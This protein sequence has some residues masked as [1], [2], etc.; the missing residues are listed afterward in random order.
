MADT[1]QRKRGSTAQHRVYIGANGEFTYNTDTKTI[2]VHDGQRMGGFPLA[3]ADALT[4]FR[5]NEVSDFTDRDFVVSGVIPNDDTVPQISEGTEVLSV[6]ID[7][8]R[9][10][11]KLD[12]SV[13]GCASPI[14]GGIITLALFVDG[15][16][17]ASQVWAVNATGV[18]YRNIS[19]GLLTEA[20]GKVG[21]VTVSLRVGI[22]DNSNGNG[23]TLGGRNGNVQWGGASRVTLSAKE[24]RNEEL[25]WCG[26]QLS[27]NIPTGAPGRTH[28]LAIEPNGAEPVAGNLLTHRYHHH[29]RVIE[30]LGRVWV[31]YTTAGKNEDQRGLTVV[32]QSSP[33]GTVAFGA[34]AQ[35]F[36]YVFPFN[37]D[38]NGQVGHCIMT[39]N[40]QVLDG[41]LYLVGGVDNIGPNNFFE[42]LA[43]VA[44]EC[45]ADGGLGTPFRISP[46]QYVSPTG[47]VPTYDGILSPQLYAYSKVW[48]M[49]CGSSPS[50]VVQSE[51]V[52]WLNQSGKWFTEPSVFRIDDNPLNLVKT[53]RHISG[54]TATALN[55]RLWI[56]RSRDGG[57]TWGGARR[58][59][60]P[61]VA[62]ASGT[63][64]SD[65][66]VALV[67]NLVGPNRDPL[68]LALF[69]EGEVS[70][71]YYA[72]AGLS[73]T[74]VYPGIYKGGAEAYPDIFEG[75]DSIWISYSA[76][77]EKIYVT[78]VP[79]ALL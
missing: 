8:A 13:S 68:F 56:Q 78:R 62:V 17:S 60:I 39:R 61:N 20:L 32:A 35:A 4:S 18:D 59:D 70:A 31:A 72:R 40:F 19:G 11:S 21:P 26:N 57:L 79:K 65:G 46:D 15:A 47:W 73:P 49:W 50:G 37:A 64:L 76:A 74:P 58:T 43:L 69:S 1:I 10:S 41:K 77:K 71:L 66:R 67:G 30:H 54:N 53:W 51:W 75:S 12:I 5:L 9:K 2:H 45:R 25:S 63:R 16:S 22:N 42:G 14:N 28:Y 29:T 6:V 7:V 44:V 33:I 48:G 38:D 3:R 52:G 36:P 23:V 34:P 24:I 27:G 55:D